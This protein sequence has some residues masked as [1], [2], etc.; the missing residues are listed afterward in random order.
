MSG[1]KTRAM[2][3]SDVVDGE[4]VASVEL[5]TT[6]ERVFQA[7]ASQE[8]VDWW[9]NPGVFDTREWTGDVRTGGR[10]RASGNARGAPYTLEGVFLEVD[11]PRKLV[12]TWHRVGAPG[13]P[14]TLT[15][16]LEPIVGGTRLTVRHAGLD[17]PDQLDNVGAGW[18]S[19]FDRLSDILSADRA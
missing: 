11:P 1:I 4:I 17:A 8:V 5:A 13:T 18:R 10:W 15:Y 9:V 19:S 6:P 7:L 12:Q 14:S 2:A 16:L 3:G